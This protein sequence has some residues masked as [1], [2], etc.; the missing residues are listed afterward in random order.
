MTS[1]TETTLHNKIHVKHGFPFKSEYFASEGDYIILTPGNFYE[2]GG[3]KQQQGKEKFYTGT[4]LESYL[5]KKGD[6]I[7][8]MTEQAEGLLGS[9]A[10]IPLDDLYLHNQRLGLITVDENK[11]DRLFLY[12]LFKS[13]FIRDQIQGSSSGTKVKHTSP[14]RIYN[15]KVYLPSVAEQEKIAAVLST[16]DAKIELN[17]QINTELESLAKTIYDYWFVQFD[18]P[19]DFDRSQPDEHGK[20]YKSSGGEMVWSDVLDREIPAGWE[21]KPLSEWLANDKA[22]DWGK[23]IEQGNFTKQVICIRGT[24]INGLN[25]N[26]DLNA[27]IRYILG[28]NSHKLLEPFDL[29]VEISGGSP[30]QSTGR[31]GYISPETLTRFSSPMI[32]SNFCKALSLKNIKNIYYFFYL[33]NDIYQN[34][35]LFNYEGKTSGIKNL[36]FDSFVNSY[37]S[38]VPDTYLIEKFFNIRQSIQAQQQNNLRQNQQLTQLRDWL[39]PMLMNGQVRV[40]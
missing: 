27:P 29:I 35:I 4:F 11:I 6:L 18:F 23:D 30:S 33:W 3:F 15:L 26:G 13:D 16:L 12:H 19:Y 34:K 36:L 31:L 25:G 28:K 40:K 22:G 9:T 5:L 32:C 17:N 24:D 7:V 1:W 38:I 10:I 20:P 39:L 21:V 8:A 2:E 37:Q 14:D